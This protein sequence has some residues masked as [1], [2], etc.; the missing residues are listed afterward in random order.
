MYHTHTEVILAEISNI[1]IIHITQYFLV[2]SLK[3]N[4]WNLPN[5]LA[6]ISGI[7]DDFFQGGSVP[8][9]TVETKLKRDVNSEVVRYSNHWLMRVAHRWRV[10]EYNPVF[11]R[12]VGIFLQVVQ[13][14]SQLSLGPGPAE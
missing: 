14:Q 4:Q 8:L 11:V 5:I 9:V 13:H 7:F 2:R 3:R 12:P 6:Y 10:D 1:N